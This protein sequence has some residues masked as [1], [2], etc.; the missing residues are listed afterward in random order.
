MSAR[1]ALAL[2]GVSL[3]ATLWL[4]RGLGVPETIGMIVCG[5]VAGCALAAWT[6]ARQKTR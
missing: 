3:V 6:A 2:L 1:A 4:A 5:F